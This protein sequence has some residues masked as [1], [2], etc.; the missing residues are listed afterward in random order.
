MMNME[1]FLQCWMVSVGTVLNQMEDLMKIVFKW[2]TIC[3]EI[4]A[5]TI[6]IVISYL[7]LYVRLRTVSMGFFHLKFNLF[8]KIIHL[9]KC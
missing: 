1:M 6:L 8:K 5:L 2:K 9:S 3:L 7:L 4:E